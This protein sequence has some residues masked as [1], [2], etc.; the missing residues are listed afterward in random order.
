MAR[1]SLIDDHPP[2]LAALIERIRG[3]RRGRLLNIYRMLL[4]S[5]SIASAWLEFN[6]AIRFDTHLDGPT[7]ELAIMLVAILNG[8]DYIV[9]AHGT[10]YALQEGLTR[11]QVEGL[12]D[13]RASGA[14]DPRQRALLAYVDVITR[15]VDVPDEVFDRVR[16]HYSEQQLVELTVLIG[17]YNMHTRVLKALRIDPEPAAGG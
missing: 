9:R 14:Y 15:Q 13:W 6:S 3:A 16:E 7:R 4:H 17:A 10:N 1:V 8:V 12:T 5:P 2:E 11:E